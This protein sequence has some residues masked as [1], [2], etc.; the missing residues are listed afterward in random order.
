MTSRFTMFIAPLLLGIVWMSAA[1]VFITDLRAVAAVGVFA[2]S[3]TSAILNEDDSESRK[4][5][6][7]R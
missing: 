5:R 2:A 6:S 1:E 4:A 7:K 3:I